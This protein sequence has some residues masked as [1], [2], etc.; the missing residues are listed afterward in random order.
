M[1]D[2]H[3]LGHEGLTHVL[4]LRQFVFTA[5][6]IAAGTATRSYSASMLDRYVALCWTLCSAAGPLRI[7]G[8]LHH[9]CA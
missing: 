7:T 6:G 8:S 1:Q 4:I 2:F 3:N 5:A 9:L